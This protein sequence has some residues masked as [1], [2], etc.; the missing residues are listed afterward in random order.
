MKTAECIEQTH[1][2]WFNY[3]SFR[4]AAHIITTDKNTQVNNGI[5]TLLPL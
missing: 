4:R 3:L 2:L 5:K 1:A